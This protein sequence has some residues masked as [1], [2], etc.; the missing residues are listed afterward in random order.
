MAYSYVIQTSR[1]RVTSLMTKLLWVLSAAVILVGCQSTREQLVAQGYSEAFASGY[2]D[3]CSSGRSAAMALGGFRKNVKVYLVDA[4][5]ATGWDD[6]FR[7]CQVSADKQD[8]QRRLLD[9]KD[10]RDW[11]HTKDQ[12]FGRA[13]GNSAHRH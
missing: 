2:D 10:E 3:G 1:L 6:G 12:N 5:Y 4:Q 7:Q 11:Q 8:E 13:L 9:T